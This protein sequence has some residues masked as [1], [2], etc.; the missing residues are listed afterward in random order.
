MSL[1]EA[2]TTLKVRE[3]GIRFHGVTIRIRQAYR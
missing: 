1:D 3:P 2:V